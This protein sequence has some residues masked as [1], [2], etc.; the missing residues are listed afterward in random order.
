M[1]DI[2]S[3]DGLP[4]ELFE[5]VAEYLEPNDLR[6]L[7]LVNR[8]CASKALRTFAKVWFAQKSFL[9]CDA[10]SLE[11]ARSIA[12]HAAY[13][14]ALRKIVLFVDEL[15]DWERLY[16]ILSGDIVS[17]NEASL[18]DFLPAWEYMK[19]RQDK[20]RGSCR[21]FRLLKDTFKALAKYGKLEKIV[22]EDL[23]IYRNPR[24]LITK[25]YDWFLELGLIPPRY[26]DHRPLSIVMEALGS[27]SLLPRSFI[28]N[29][30]TWFPLI[31]ELSGDSRFLE[32]CD[33]VL[34]EVEELV[35]TA[36]A[37]DGT[38][39]YDVALFLSTFINSKVLN[40]LRLRCAD[41][42]DVLGDRLYERFNFDIE[43]YDWTEPT[44]AFDRLI[45]F[46]TLLQLGHMP[47]LT[48]LGLRGRGWFDRHDFARFI[49]GH[50]KLEQVKSCFWYP[51]T[52]EQPED[53]QFDNED[54]W[55]D[56]HSIPRHVELRKQ[57]HLWFGLE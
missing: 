1:E 41:K 16:D 23:G 3:L 21:D 22:I 31:T 9:L 50:N 5:L 14:P 47:C 10:D 44:F 57:D 12:R 28:M 29:T 7:R 46:S 17:E 35:I 40:T 25:R 38:D 13:G 48:E 54:E 52:Q 4:P 34:N 51:E 24:P 36:S 56:W 27:S 45:V 19:L 15:G 55:K 53:W 32:M 42:Y 43:D 2:S 26:D 18:E 8:E 30:S 37:L 33:K 39:E 20:F 49:Q 6:C 11:V